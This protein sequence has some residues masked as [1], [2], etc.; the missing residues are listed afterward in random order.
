MKHN[1]SIKMNRITLTIV[2]ILIVAVSTGLY[3][4]GRELS[5]LKQELELNSQSAK[6][7]KGD[8]VFV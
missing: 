3:L 4:Q 8:I 5:K 6:K 1:R 7:E 2:S